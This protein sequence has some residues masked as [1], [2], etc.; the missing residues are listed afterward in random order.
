M[1][2]LLLVATFIALCTAYVQ[3]TDENFSE[4]IGEHDEWILDL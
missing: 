2:I 3:V 4:L 1:R